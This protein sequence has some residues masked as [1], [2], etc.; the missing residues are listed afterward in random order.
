KFLGAQKKALLFKNGMANTVSEWLNSAEYLLSGGNENVV[1][2]Y[3]GTRGLDDSTRFTMDSGVIPVLKERTHLPVSADPSHPAG[4]RNYVESMALAAVASGADMLE[5]EVHNDPERALS[6]SK[7]QLSFDEFSR[8]ARNARK[9]SEVI[10][11][12][13]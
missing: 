12:M 2:C 10:G 1:L 8:L 13:H 11:S 7:Q 4:N 6:D 3:R 5:I 9:L